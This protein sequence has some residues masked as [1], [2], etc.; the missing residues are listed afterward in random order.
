MC[1][2]GKYGTVIN[3]SRL[4]IREK[5]SIDGVI[6]CEIACQTKLVID[7]EESTDDFYKVYTPAGIEGFCMKKFVEI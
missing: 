6:I 5:P 4:N 3:C 2:D 1:D 7:K